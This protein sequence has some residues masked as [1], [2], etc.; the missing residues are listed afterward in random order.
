MKLFIILSTI[1]LFFL[2]SCSA[3]VNA[4]DSAEKLNAQTVQDAL[5]TQAL[6]ANAANERL[7]TSQSS[8]I[9][10]QNDTI[11]AKDRII[12]EQSSSVSTFAIV[13]I[14]LFMIVAVLII[15]S[16]A[17]RMKVN[18][19]INEARVLSGSSSQFYIENNSDL[20]NQLN[21]TRNQLEEANR[22]IKFLL[23]EKKQLTET[24]R[25]TGQ[26]W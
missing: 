25:L 9:Q 17:L 24:K 22:A 13:A 10:M 14:V 18:T 11:A 1:V 4:G 16:I 6:A 15:Y 20:L 3:G 19:L 26:T 21:L 5:Q 7:F 8:I 12:L 2:T 23:A